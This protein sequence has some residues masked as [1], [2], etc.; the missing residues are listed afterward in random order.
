M[1]KYYETKTKKLLFLIMPKISGLEHASI[2]MDGETC[3]KENSEGEHQRWIGVEI[4][5]A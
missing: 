3:K 1:I 4:S 2:L 5:D